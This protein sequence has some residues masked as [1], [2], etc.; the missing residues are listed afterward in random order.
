MFYADGDADARMK[1]GAKRVALSSWG[2]MVFPRY[3]LDCDT[4]SE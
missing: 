3:C 2:A 1:T 4:L